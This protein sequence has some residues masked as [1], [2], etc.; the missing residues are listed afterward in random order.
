M[1]CIFLFKDNLN[2]TSVFDVKNV[3]LSIY[4]KSSNMNLFINELK[5]YSPFKTNVIVYIKNGRNFSLT[6][7][8]HYSLMNDVDLKN[9]NNEVLNNRNEGTHREYYM[10]SKILVYFLIDNPINA[11][12]LAKWKK[13]EFINKKKKKTNIKAI[14]KII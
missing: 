14:S 1:K 11:D 5:Q 2:N 8:E 3:C 6:N 10:H 4:Y 13:R 12:E 7:N 9:I